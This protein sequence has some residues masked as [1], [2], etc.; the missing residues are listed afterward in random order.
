MARSASFDPH[1]LAIP[2]FILC[3]LIVA[4]AIPFYLLAQPAPI[5]PEEVYTQPIYY[6]KL[7]RTLIPLPAFILL[8]RSGIALRLEQRFATH[9]TRWLVRGGFILAV[10]CLFDLFE[11]PYWTTYHQHN[12]DFG[13]SHIPHAEWLKN[14][15]L[16]KIIPYTKSLLMYLLVFCAMPLFGKRWWIGAAVLVFVLYSVLPEVLSRKIP[17]DLVEHVTPMEPGPHRDALEQIAQDAA[18]PLT[19]LTLDQSERSG[20]VTMYLTGKIGREYLVVSDTWLEKMNPAQSAAAV[21][22][23]LGHLKTRHITVPAHKVLALFFFAAAM[24][25]VHRHYGGKAPEPA[26]RLHI[27]LAVLFAVYL[28]AQLK[29]PIAHAITRYQERTA[30]AYALELTKSPQAFREAL[31]TTAEINLEPNRHPNWAYFL[32][33]SHP[34]LEKRLAFCEKWSKNGINE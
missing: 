25:I 34:S 29:R 19:L 3:A 5:N 11:M 18:R 24:L 17:I 6:G 30:D 9:P 1:K 2:G 31:L 14:Y 8:L 22:H 33:S 20:T 10:F 4:Q 16:Q 7:L 13:L 23:E 15:A 12:N 26:Q 27:V 21:A 28:G 32:W